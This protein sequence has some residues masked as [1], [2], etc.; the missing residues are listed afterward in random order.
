[1][2]AQHGTSTLITSVRRAL[3]LVDLVAS[4]GRPVQVKTLAR[5]AGLSLGTAYNLTRTLVHEGYLAAE[6][7]GLVLGPRFPALRPATTTGVTLARTRHAL[8]CAAEAAH[9]TA[10][11]SRFEDGEIRILDVVECPGSPHLDLQVGVTDAAHATA[12]GKQVLAGLS[13][14]ERADYLGRHRLERFTAHTM[15]DRD[16]LVTQ[17]ARSATMVVD[18]EEYRSGLTC[19]AVPVPA[20]RI[21]ASL[22]VALPPGTPPR[23]AA[24][25]AAALRAPAS[26]LAL[27][28]A[29]GQRFSI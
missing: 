8:R 5:A 15:R 25:A 19:V 21:V 14:A 10:Y 23:D 4:S 27:H 7:D 6:P 12:F 20:D 3:E 18:H 28:L 17:L 29:S 13:T 24:R 2:A 1:M 26:V 22:A 9:A 16:A 11:L